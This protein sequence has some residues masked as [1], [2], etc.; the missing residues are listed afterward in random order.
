MQLLAWLPCVAGVVVPR[1]DQLVAASLYLAAPCASATG[2]ENFPR[3]DE[4]QNKASVLTSRP[5]EWLRIRNQLDADEEYNELADPIQRSTP[6]ERLAQVLAVVDSFERLRP[7]VASADRSECRRVAAVLALAPF[8]KQ[9]FKRIFN[10]YSDNIYYS[11]PDRA[12][13]YLLGGAPPTTKQTIQYLY[14]NQALDNIELLRGELNDIVLDP[15]DLVVADAL[16]F[17]G[18]ASKALAAY[19]D[20]APSSDLVAARNLLA[21][22]PSS[23]S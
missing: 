10:A 19:V 8:E 18:E 16:A 2:L 9:S 23:S 12:N 6:V 4:G 21:K 3:L 15:A 1:R 20:L 13:A 14:R 22:R 11:N 17:H 7:L 5:L